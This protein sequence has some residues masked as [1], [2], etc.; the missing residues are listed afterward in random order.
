[1]TGKTRDG[2][3]IRRRGFGRT[4]RA[5]AVL[6]VLL[7]GAANYL[8]LDHAIKQADSFVV[9]T[10]RTL[11]RNDFSHQID[12][13]VQYQSQLSFW[14]KSFKELA[15]GMPGD[16]FVRDQLRDWM[17]ADFGFSWMIFTTP[18]HEQ[19]LGVHRGAKVSERTARETLRWVSDLTRKAEVA[20]RAALAPTL[21]GWEV[22]SGREDPD[23]LTPALP[24]I[25]VSG[26]RL[27]DRVMSVVVVQ[28]VI[29]RT[30]YIPA[31]RL[32]PTLLVTVKPISQK[33]LADAQERLGVKGLGFSPIVTDAPGLAMTPVGEDAYN[34]MVA[35]WRP[36]MPGSFVWKSALPQIGMF[37]LVFAGVMLFGTLRFSALVKALQHSEARNAFLARHDSLTGLRNRS[38]FDEKAA[39]I[40]GRDGGTPFAIIALDLDRF[41]AVNDRHGHAAGDAVLQAVA[42]RFAERIGAHGCA[43]RFGGDE[44]CMLLAGE[45]SR[46]SLVGLAEGLVRDAQLPIAHD[47]QLLLIGGSAGIAQ[48]PDHGRSLHDVMV[49]ADAALYA[50]KNAGR[51][52]AAHAGDLCMEEIIEARASRAA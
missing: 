2:H 45:Y 33:M 19:V 50:A 28:A 6:I 10:E 38:G 41:K 34:P 13:V 5:A 16:I 7:F 3:A 29:P 26:I 22:K 20:Y 15:G 47:G 36:N 4:I 39:E 40:A 24:A 1:M 27:I 17:W 9:E 31:D 52:R 23:L 46:E 25:H 48:F 32:R 30:R 14:D 42:R 21:G 35:S 37:V 44:F 8:V 18:D 49:M 12:Q 11:V 43:A 51:N